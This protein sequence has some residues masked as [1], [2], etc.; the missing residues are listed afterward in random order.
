MDYASEVFEASVRQAA[1]AILRLSAALK[2]DKN[3]IRMRIAPRLSDRGVLRLGYSK[4]KFL[5]LFAS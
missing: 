4:Q 2:T 5:Q 1:H 3:I